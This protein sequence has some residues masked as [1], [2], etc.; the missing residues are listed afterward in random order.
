MHNINKTPINTSY[1]FTSQ[2]CIEAL[3]I[4]TL[5]KLKEKVL[6]Y[7]F[8]G[9]EGIILEGKE[10]F[11]FAKLTLEQVEGLLN[12]DIDYFCAL[13]D[14]VHFDSYE[15]GAELET[16]PITNPENEQKLLY[17][18]YSLLGCQEADGY[19]RAY[20]R[21]GG[22]YYD[23]QY[24]PLLVREEDSDRMTIDRDLLYYARKAYTALT[25]KG[26]EYVDLGQFLEVITCKEEDLDRIIEDT[27]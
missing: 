25:T 21:T 10:F 9:Q 27:F 16:G 13:Q 5:E 8:D 19:E 6:W 2:K 15:K 18:E 4:Y 17:N 3:K 22:R 14:G 11:P 23:W 24:S 26:K 1:M 12:G 7:T 20:I